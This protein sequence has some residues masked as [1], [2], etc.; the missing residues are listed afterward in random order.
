MSIL[1]FTE[2]L[3]PIM[4]LIVKIRNTNL[5]L[6]F[7]IRLLKVRTLYKNLKYMCIDPT[8]K[9]DDTDSCNTCSAFG[10]SSGNCN[11]SRKTWFISRQLWYQQNNISR[12]INGQNGSVLR[13]Y[14]YWNNR[15]YYKT[16]E[17]LWNK[18]GIRECVANLILADI[19]SV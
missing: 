11:T 17:R 10:M 19:S 5:K 7:G 9:Y 16:A 1:K 6:L 4:L 18:C 14:S 8:G 13:S 15:I 3:V 12:I 2:I